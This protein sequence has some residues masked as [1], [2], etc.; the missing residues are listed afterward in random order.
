MLVKVGDR[1]YGWGAEVRDLPNN[2][3]AY[4]AKL[5]SEADMGALSKAIRA[6]GWLASWK[7]LPSERV[8]FLCEP[9]KWRQAVTAFGMDGQYY[10]VKEEPAAALSVPSAAPAAVEPGPEPPVVT[11]AAVAEALLKPIPGLPDIDIED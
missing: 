1:T 6:A 8:V 10:Q 3:E 4:G 5:L 7:R 11:P 9:G 2:A